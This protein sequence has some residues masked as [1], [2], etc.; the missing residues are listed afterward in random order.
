MCYLNF[1]KGNLGRLNPQAVWQPLDLMS[2]NRLG[3][4]S[5]A[6]GFWADDLDDSMLG[7]FHFQLMRLF[8]GSYQRHGG[9]AFDLFIKDL[10]LE[11]QLFS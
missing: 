8:T 4:H 10:V 3:I 11:V 7:N 2:L 5:I 6:D 1:F 9:K